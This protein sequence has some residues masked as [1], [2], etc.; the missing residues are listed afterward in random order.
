MADDAGCPWPFDVIVMAIL[1][2]H[3]KLLEQV[4]NQIE[5]LD[6]PKGERHPL[7]PRGWQAYIACTARRFIFAPMKKTFENLLRPLGTDWGGGVQV[8][9]STDTCNAWL[10]YSWLTYLMEGAES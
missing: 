9:G 5:D 6:W 1:L 3:Q 10:A 4:H 2:G 8:R 7:R